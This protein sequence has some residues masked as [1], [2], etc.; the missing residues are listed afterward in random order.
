MTEYYV[1]IEMGGEN[2]TFESFV[3]L[4][5]FLKYFKTQFLKV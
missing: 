5:R 4:M 2:F 3:T 1:T